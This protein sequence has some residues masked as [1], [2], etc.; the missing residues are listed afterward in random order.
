MNK[1]LVIIGVITF[2]GYFIYKGIK[3][4]QS[5]LNNT[6]RPN[7]TDKPIKP[8]DK[9][10]LVQDLKFEYLKKAIE[11][12]CN[13]SNQNQI[14]IRPR[15][16]ILANQFVITFPY[17]IGFDQ[18]C[19]LINYLKYAN[20]LCLK[21]DYR[22]VI[23]AWCTPKEGDIWMTEDI[24]NK[25]AMI[26]IPDWDKEYDNVYLTTQDDLGF[27]MGFAIGEQKKLNSPAMQFE[28]I[29]IVLELIEDKEAIDFK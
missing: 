6:A 28:K 14:D 17:G 15:L 16:T 5:D 22:P 2:L 11:Q 12:F 27:K 4:S 23:R 10:I 26:F 7:E 29:P 3:T 19:F 20:E 8:N 9:I 1:A 18:F 13:M 21:P 25:K 24:A